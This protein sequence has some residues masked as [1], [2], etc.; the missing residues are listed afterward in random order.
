[1]TR[2]FYKISSL[3]VLVALLST[4]CA[5][6]TPEP[7][8][9]PTAVPTEVPT[10]GEGVTICQV[11]DIMGME[12]ETLNA[13][14]WTGIEKAEA[15]LGITGQYL[16][17]QSEADVE[18]NI[19]S[20]LGEDCDLIIASGF[21]LNAAVEAAA[22]SN[23]NQ[24]FYMVD[25]KADLSLN[26]VKG[27]VFNVGEAAFLAG[28]AAAGVTKSAKVGTFGSA[29][30]TTVTAFMDGFYMG[31]QHYNKVH[32][33]NIEVLG[34]DPIEKTGLFME[35]SATA[36]DARAFA[37]DLVDRGADIIMPVVGAAGLGAV[38][39]ALELRDIYIIGVTTDWARISPKYVDA[40]LTSVLK[41]ADDTTLEVIQSVVE[42]DWS[43]GVMTGSLSNEGV[44]L[45]PVVVRASASSA[46]VMSW[47]DA[48]KVEIK[49]VEVAIKA[50]EIQTAP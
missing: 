20:F 36:D 41:N 1:M 12:D 19:N 10:L 46:D 29:Q 13:L 48:L 11:T 24:R 38:D 47:F 16:E 8:A 3:F 40:I 5:K 28:Y 23:P 44:T 30:I 27:Q 45:A 32:E 21:S 6:S 15:Q 25:A 17:S 22:E 4:G 33:T 50:G 7:T 39:L 34:W 14:V 18:K 31:V 35:G 26:N 49:E 42:G 9:V 2:K 37:E 43:G